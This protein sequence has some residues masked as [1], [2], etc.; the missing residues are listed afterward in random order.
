MQKYKLWRL[1]SFD[2]KILLQGVYSGFAVKI[3]PNIGA[4]NLNT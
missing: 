3:N 2:V 4:E 1:R